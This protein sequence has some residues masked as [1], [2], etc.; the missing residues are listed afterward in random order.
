MNRSRQFRAGLIGTMAFGLLWTAGCSSPT[1]V[2]TEGAADQP[3]TPFH[4]QGTSATSSGAG[5]SSG[6]RENPAKP[7][8]G[9]P[10]HDLQN[11]PAG[12][13]LTVRLKSS[14]SAGNSSKDNSFDAIVDEPVVLEGNTLIPRGA[15][16]A[17][18]VES[19][20]ASTLKPS[21]GYVR[22]SLESVHIGGFDVPV[23]TASLFARL[24]PVSDDSST[25]FLLEKGRRLT[26]RIT[27]PVN[28]P[29]QRALAAH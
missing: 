6:S 4:D 8:K 7:E 2:P 10:F 28:L 26:F 18:R 11:L 15:T 25:L 23:Q 21:R 5:D 9:L 24:A 27:E 22:L 29:N 1:G 20:Q 17:G 13:L 3:Q 14:V 19:A 16:A 12:T